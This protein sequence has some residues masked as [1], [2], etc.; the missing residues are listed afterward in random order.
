MALFS[1]TE[2]EDL[3]NS[4]I[5]IYQYKR[6]RNWDQRNAYCRGCWVLTSDSRTRLQQAE[7]TEALRR[8]MF[9]SRDYTEVSSALGPRAMKED[10]HTY[11]SMATIELPCGHLWGIDWRPALRKIRWGCLSGLSE[12]R[13]M[14]SNAPQDLGFDLLQFRLQLQLN[15]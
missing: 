4:A 12:G 7:V 14:V 15:V 2:H 13:A 1:S 3:V 8:P 11:V 6:L 9:F 10:E 5:S